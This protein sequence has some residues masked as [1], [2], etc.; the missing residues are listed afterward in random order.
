MIDRLPYRLQLNESPLL[1]DLEEDE[2]KSLFKRMEHLCFESDRTI[3]AQGVEEKGLWLIGEGCC[4]VVR[5]NQ[6]GTKE[7]ILAML[8]PGTVFGE[9]SFFQQ[10]AHSATVRSV[11]PVSVHKLTQQGFTD[12]LADNGRAAGKILT[13]LVRVQSDRLNMMDQWVCELMDRNQTENGAT[14]TLNEWHQFRSKLYSEWN[15]Y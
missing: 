5:G 15:F 13:N 12:L 10:P 9:M 11:T 6:S 7:R 1:R 3:L 8:G 2:V 4:E 14:H